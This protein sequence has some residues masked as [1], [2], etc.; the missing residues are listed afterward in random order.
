MLVGS[1]GMAIGV[2]FSV[3]NWAS[4]NM[5]RRSRRSVGERLACG[6]LV[7][8]ACEWECLL[9]DSADSWLAFVARGV[10]WETNVSQQQG[11][12]LLRIEQP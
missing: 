1:L 5:K 4:R 12:F 11:Y 6:F 3:P 2:R 9:E 10:R 7:G 8:K